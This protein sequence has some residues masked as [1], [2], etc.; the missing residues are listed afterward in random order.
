VAPDNPRRRAGERSA[1]GGR[2]RVGRG[3]AE[4]EAEADRGRRRR[5]RGGSKNIDERELEK[6]RTRIEKVSPFLCF[7]S[8]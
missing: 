6:V 2:R 5:E 1:V 8:F 3:A 4:A 7:V